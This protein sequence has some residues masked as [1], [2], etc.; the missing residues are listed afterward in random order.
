[1]GVSLQS[2]FR[3]SFA[4]KVYLLQMLSNHGLGTPEISE[5]TTVGL[6]G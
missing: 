3:F 5:T 6:Q 1:M 4:V 2:R